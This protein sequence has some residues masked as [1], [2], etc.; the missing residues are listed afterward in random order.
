MVNQNFSFERRSQ[1]ESVP[2][3]GFDLQ[4]REIGISNP[5][6][7]DVKKIA[8]G[9]RK[10]SLLRKEGQPLRKHEK[11]STLYFNRDSVSVPK[12]AVF[13]V[14]AGISGAFAPLNG[15]NVISGA[16]FFFRSILLLSV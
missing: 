9:Q 6:D 12:S 14:P 2:G 15:H 4:R 1:S 13:E 5:P 11:R 16:E 8:L 10:L 3:P 7:C